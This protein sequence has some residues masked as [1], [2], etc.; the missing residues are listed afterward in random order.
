MASAKS[1]LQ[2]AGVSAPDIEDIVKPGHPQLCCSK[3]YLE[4]FPDNNGLTI[5]HPNQFVRGA[6][7]VQTKKKRQKIDVSPEKDNPAAAAASATSK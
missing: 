4:R 2:W 1:Y 6:V 7:L 5:N 3:Y